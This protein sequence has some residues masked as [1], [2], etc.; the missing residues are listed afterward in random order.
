ML[1]IAPTAFILAKDTGKYHQNTGPSSASKMITH[2]HITHSK[3]YLIR[4]RI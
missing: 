1:P 4:K 3:F 2:M